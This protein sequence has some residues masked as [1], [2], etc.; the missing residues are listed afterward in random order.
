MEAISKLQF[1]GKQ[2]LLVQLPWIQDVSQSYIYMQYVFKTCE[3][4]SAGEKTNRVLDWFNIYHKF[5][6]VR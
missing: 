1:L 3:T 4:L 2:A 6:F 5:K